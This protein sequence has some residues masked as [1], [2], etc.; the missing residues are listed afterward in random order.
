MDEFK[1]HSN[2]SKIIIT[3]KSTKEGFIK[4]PQQFWRKLYDKDMDGFDES[5]METLEGY[6]KRYCDIENIVYDICEECYH[7][8]KA[9]KPKYHEY[10]IFSPD[11]KSKLF[12]ARKYKAYDNVNKIITE[13]LCGFKIIT[14]DNNINSQIVQNILESLVIDPQIITK[15]QELCY[16]IIVKKSDEVNIFYDYGNSFFYLTDWIKDILFSL[17][18]SFFIHGSNQEYNKDA[19]CVILDNPNKINKFVEIGVKNI[20]VRTKK[21]HMYDV[22]N[23]VE[24]MND[25]EEFVKINCLDR[26]NMNEIKNDYKSVND[27]FFKSD[28]LLSHFLKWCCMR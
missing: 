9:Y 14:I 11:Q 12:N 6:L 10:A 8:V 21:K 17:K 5:R 19:R 27:I 28:L 16:S 25:N 3:D 24:Y 7:D 2:V 20:I 15:Y 18:H 13:N 23:Y 26:K 1:K 22:N 4:F